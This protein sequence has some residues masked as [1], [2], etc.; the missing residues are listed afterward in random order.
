MN[1]D[2]INKINDVEFELMY[3]SLFGTPISVSTNKDSNKKYVN[4]MVNHLITGNAN[5]LH[6][7]ELDKEKMS[8]ALQERKARMMELLLLNSKNGELMF[9]NENV[10][11][12]DIRENIKYAVNF[13]T[14]FVTMTQFMYT[15][16][17]PEIQ[18]EMVKNFAK[19]ITMLKKQNLLSDQAVNFATEHMMN[20]DSRF[21]TLLAKETNKD[22]VAFVA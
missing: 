7:V 20:V 10:A 12:T 19:N 8:Y 22:E 3:D 21:K 1:Q 16:L 14:K 4:F 13:P 17:K 15:N 11:K 18:T 5:K 6:C 9:K 2:K